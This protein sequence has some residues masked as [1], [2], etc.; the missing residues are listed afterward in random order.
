MKLKFEPAGRPKSKE[1]YYLT[2]KENVC[3]VCGK[4]EAFLSKSIVPRDYRQHFPTCLKDHHSHDILVMCP[5]CH[6]V[7]SDHDLTFRM[8]LAEEYSA[9]V[10]NKGVCCSLNFNRKKNLKEQSTFQFSPEFFPFT[11]MCFVYCKAPST[12]NRDLQLHA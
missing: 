7:A 2:F 5:E 9:P 10:G 8:K 12:R 6:R 1:D 4:S 3:V 11:S